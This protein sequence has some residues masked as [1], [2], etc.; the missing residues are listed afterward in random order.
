MIDVHR[1]EAALVVVGI[2]K[3]ELLTTV[4]RLTVKQNWSTKAPVSRAASL[5][6]GAFSKREIVDWEASGAPLSGALPTASF[7]SGSWRKRSR[8]LASL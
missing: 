8:S 1:Q 2:P 5:F 7:K 4:S 3:T 6:R